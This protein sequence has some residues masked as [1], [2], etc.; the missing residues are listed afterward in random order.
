MVVLPHTCANTLY[1]MAGRCRYS[2]VSEMRGSVGPILATVLVT[3][4]LC[5]IAPAQEHDPGILLNAACGLTPAGASLCSSSV[6]SLL[7]F[8]QIAF[9][10]REFGR[11]GTIWITQTQSWFDG[12]AAE[13]MIRRLERACWSKEIVAPNPRD[14]AAQVEDELR[15]SMAAP[16]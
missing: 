12:T 1:P 7:S 6:E 16:P 5:R 2:A 11:S 15:E 14:V 4:T 3:T 8:D 13:V 10:I 9:I